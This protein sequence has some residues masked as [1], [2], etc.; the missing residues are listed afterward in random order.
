MKN[1]TVQLNPDAPWAA[2]SYIELHINEDYNGT[3]LGTVTVS[4]YPI[5]VVGIRGTEADDFWAWVEV[6]REPA[7]T[8]VR[9]CAAYLLYWLGVVTED[10]HQE[11][12]GDM[13]D[14][15]WNT[16]TESIG[17]HGVLE[18]VERCWAHLRQVEE[19]D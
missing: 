7:R 17:E 1:S 18:F 19:D 10:Q 5:M 15:A 3:K 12:L 13:D 14:A 16:L 4:G 8:Q 9:D 11:W 2:E 6:D